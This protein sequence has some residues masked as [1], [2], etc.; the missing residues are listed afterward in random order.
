MQ[1]NTLF[2]DSMA[3][4]SVYKSKFWATALMIIWEVLL[5]VF[6]LSIKAMTLDLLWEVL[7]IISLGSFN[8]SNDFGSTCF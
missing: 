5:L 6:G 4:E 1:E 7:L 8:Q 3:R 2:C